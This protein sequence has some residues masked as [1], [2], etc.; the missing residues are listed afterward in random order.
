MSVGRVRPWACANSIR[1][2]KCKHSV[3]IIQHMALCVCSELKRPLDWI[4]EYRGLCRRAYVLPCGFR[5]EANA[6]WSYFKSFPVTNEIC[7][8]PNASVFCFARF[9]VWK[10]HKQDTIPISWQ[11]I[12][13]SSVEGNLGRHMRSAAWYS[14]FLCWYFPVPE[15]CSVAWVSKRNVTLGISVPLQDEWM[16][17]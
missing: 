16:C 2:Q 15:K 6:V 12:L 10:Q 14:N 17:I 5:Q 3:V 8:L 7:H 11:L 13:S 4:Q 1:E 9:I